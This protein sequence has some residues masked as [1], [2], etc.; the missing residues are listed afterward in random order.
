VIRRLKG[1]PLRRALR[2]LSRVPTP[3]AISRAEAEAIA[4]AEW[5]R[6]GFLAGRPGASARAEG[7]RGSYRVRLDWGGIPIPWMEIDARTGAITRFVV[8]PR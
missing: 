7:G 6:R 8:P 3:P 2:W 4:L 5:E 1:A